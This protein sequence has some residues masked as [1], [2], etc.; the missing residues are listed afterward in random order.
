[1]SVASSPC[2][3]VCVIDPASQ[4]CAGCGRTLAEIAQW[5]GLSEAERLAIMAKL[6]KR[7]QERTPEPQRHARA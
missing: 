6:P 4:L 1:M 3:R 5:S 2:I 7:L